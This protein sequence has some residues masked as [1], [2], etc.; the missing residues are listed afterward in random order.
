MKNIFDKYNKSLDKC[1][2]YLGREKALD[3]KLYYDKSVCY[4]MTYRYSEALE[5]I[6]KAIKYYYEYY[7]EELKCNFLDESVYWL[8]KSNILMQIGKFDEAL[9][10]LDK[11]DNIVKE[12]DDSYIMSKINKAIVFAIRNEYGK[13]LDILNKLTKISS[14]HIIYLNIARIYQNMGNKCEEKNDIEDAINNYKKAIYSY[15]KAL[16]NCKDNKKKS[17]ILYQKSF[18]LSKKYDLDKVNKNEIIE[19][20]N[21]AI[22]F[23]NN[24]YKVY[25]YKGLKSNDD[26][27][28][29]NESLKAIDSILNNNEEDEKTYDIYTIL[30]N[31]QNKMNCEQVYKLIDRVIKEDFSMKIEYDIENNSLYNYMSINTNTIK[32]IKNNKLWLSHTNNFNDP[33]DPTIKRYKGKYDYI[34]NSI[35]VACLTKNYDNTLMWSHYADKHKGICVEYDISNIINKENYIIRKVNY[36][37]KAIV[38]ENSINTIYDINLLLDLFCIKSKEWEYE[39]EYR[40]L[41]HDIERLNNGK[42]IDLPIK[43]I[44]FGVET[45]ED[46]KKLIH[47]II[48]D[49]IELYQ[50]EFDK[51]ELYKMNRHKYEY[52]K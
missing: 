23:N 28:L 11:I 51:I 39:D 45:L 49:S 29:Y 2:I 43:S 30:H 8:K 22:K 48:N 41:Y 13:S 44:C 31:I 12:N 18:C 9:S 35:K 3:S 52:K 47:D 5:N 38:D 36:D 37:M 14:D 21:N 16:N 7:T 19:N 15:D 46:D 10:V 24:N 1:N 40:I 33:V 25:Y 34:L 42:L 50:M 6:D 27:N 17:D 26:K 32:T 4:Q 20:Y